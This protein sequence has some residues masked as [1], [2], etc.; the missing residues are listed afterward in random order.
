MKEKAQ[1]TAF[2]VDFI[3]PVTIIVYG[4]ARDAR[5]DA[6]TLALALWGTSARLAMTGHKLRGLPSSARPLRQAQSHGQQWGW[7]L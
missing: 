5:T 2:K 1:Y 4:L 6:L 3:F 7:E